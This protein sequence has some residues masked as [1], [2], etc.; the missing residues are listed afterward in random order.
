MVPPSFTQLQVGIG[1]VLT[2]PWRKDVSV[3][4]LQ[5]AAA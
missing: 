5:I 4:L 2:L 1:C 3:S